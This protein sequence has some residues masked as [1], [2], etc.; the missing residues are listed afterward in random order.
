MTGVQTM[1]QHAQKS[2]LSTFA[3]KTYVKRS[4]RIGTPLQGFST[5]V[6][7]H[8][9]AQAKSETL[10]SERTDS[11]Q[12]EDEDPWGLN[13][14]EAEALAALRSIGTAPTLERIFD[15]LTGIGYFVVIRN[16]FLKTEDE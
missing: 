11:D 6:S 5:E 14:L 3:T 10:A 16:Q 9:F 15:D 8:N 7:P 13:Q 12:D 4:N 1:S 2:A